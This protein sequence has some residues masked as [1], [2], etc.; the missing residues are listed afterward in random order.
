[1]LQF[2]PQFY[3]ELTVA[4]VKTVKFISGAFFLADRSAC[5]LFNCKICIVLTPGLS[6]DI[7]KAVSLV[8][9]DDHL[10]F[11]RGFVRVCMG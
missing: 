3:E 4:R 10:N 7:D 11:H 5:L 8:I 9:A 2:D 1:M 6:K